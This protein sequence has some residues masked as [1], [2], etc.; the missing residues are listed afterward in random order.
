MAILDIHEGF[1]SY[2]ILS[3]PSPVPPHQ[4]PILISNRPSLFV[5]DKRDVSYSERHPMFPSPWVARINIRMLIS[6][7]T[8]CLECEDNLS[9]RVSGGQLSCT[10]SFDQVRNFQSLVSN[11]LSGPIRTMKTKRSQTGTVRI[12]RFLSQMDLS[13]IINIG[14]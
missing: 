3:Q 5:W 4:H 13:P 8:S 6:C 7:D 1:P 2:Q 14:S 12:L 11:L 10:A 9:R